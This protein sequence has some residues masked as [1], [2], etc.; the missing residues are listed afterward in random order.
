[1]IELPLPYLSSYNC[2]MYVQE[3]RGKHQYAKQTQKSKKIQVEDMK[4]TMSE[5]KNMLQCSY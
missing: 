3:G 5:M 2:I 4:N 1:M